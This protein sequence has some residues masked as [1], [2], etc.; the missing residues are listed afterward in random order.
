M[1]KKKTLLASLLAAFGILVGG[2]AAHFTFNRAA[3]PA[4]CLASRISAKQLYDAGLEGKPIHFDRWSM[5]RCQASEADIEAA[6]SLLQSENSV[7]Y[8][9][10][11]MARLAPKEAPADVKARTAEVAFAMMRALQIRYQAAMCWP[12][13]GTTLAQAKAVDEPILRLWLA[14]YAGYNK[15]EDQMAVALGIVLVAD[16]Y[17]PPQTKCDTELKQ[18]AEQHLREWEAV[19][20]GTHPW[21]PGCTIKAEESEFVVRCAE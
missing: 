16:Q 13:M 6:K 20:K 4:Q 8:I 5:L 12:E 11:L 14:R 21:V 15:V 1:N 3:T 9:K 2:T 7:D 17:R 18:E 10:G 19:Q